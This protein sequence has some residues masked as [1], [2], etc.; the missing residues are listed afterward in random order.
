M[1]VEQFLYLSIFL[2]AILV[3]G[4]SLSSPALSEFEADAALR[5]WQ[6]TQGESI[7]LGSRP[8]YVLLTSLL[9][10]IFGR[11][12]AVARFWPVLA[13]C[14]LVLTPF[15][16]RSQLG[17]KA[18]LVLALAL[19]LDPGLVSL[20]RLAGGPMMAVGF[21]LAAVASWFAGI[22]VFAGVFTGLALLSGPAALQGA[23][24]LAAAGSAYQVLRTRGWIAVKAADETSSVAPLSSHNGPAD[25]ESAWRTGLISG[26]GTL[27]LAGTLFLR[28]PQGLSALFN[29]V[30]AY[31]Q[32]WFVFSD[33]PVL[34]LP[35]ALLAYQSIALLFAGVSLARARMGTRPA[36]T[37][38]F[39]SIWLLAALLLALLYP[40]RQ[41][42]DLSWVL[43]PLW[44]L[45]AIE[46]ARFLEFGP[47]VGLIGVVA[48]LVTV[49]IASIWLNGA[50]LS[51]SQP[52]DPNFPLRLL[53]IAGALTLIVLSTLLVGYGWSFEV[54]LR[55][56][57]WGGAIWLLFLLL[58]GTWAESARPES[59]RISLWAPAPAAGQSS[60]LIST[61]ADLG[62]WNEGQPQSLDIVALAD[63]ASLR[64]SLL[65]FSQARFSAHLASGETPSVVIT[66]QGQELGLAADY[67]GQ[68]FSWRIYP[69]WQQMTP[70]AWARWFLVR[71]APTR[72]E[73]II[74]WARDD[75]FIGDPIESRD[76]VLPLQN[77]PGDNQGDAHGPG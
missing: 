75:L 4:V 28:F 35:T 16:F 62:E 61:L 37:A 24:G 54:A 36:N 64:W 51:T 44:G 45:A 65:D 72:S 3:R 53:V 7:E 49:L 67:R 74:L 26:G 60:L 70:L 29:A 20:S 59:H 22:P 56:L 63:S 77:S 41:V 40:S 14:L 11:G 21:G 50:G 25:T 42:A 68:D 6:V 52:G 5:A 43:L 8:G 10:F 39:L 32:G 31:I 13:G 17:K 15:A 38:R 27:L 12:E 33:V 69:D 48:A 57:M 23:I 47:D 73:Q 30:P 71:E 58:S 55:G 19:C 2:L 76:E 1:T 18:A 9:F 34:R 46:L 66:P